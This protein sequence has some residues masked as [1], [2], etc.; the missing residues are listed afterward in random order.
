M[1]GLPNP[2]Q[3][4]VSLDDDPILKAAVKLYLKLSHAQGNYTA[5]Q[6]VL[7]ELHKFLTLYQVRLFLFRARILFN[8]STGPAGSFQECC[9]AI[10]GMS[11]NAIA[12]SLTVCLAFECFCTV[13]SGSA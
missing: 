3:R 2:P 5:A 11:V 9:W 6:D 8:A 1:S 13:V 10:G 4:I 7:M 12:Q